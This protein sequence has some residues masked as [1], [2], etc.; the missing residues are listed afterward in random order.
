[1]E[2]HHMETKRKGGRPRKH[3]RLQGTVAVRMSLAEQADLK[4]RSDTRNM[5]V[6]EYVRFVLF[7]QF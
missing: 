2:I 5:T 7:K 3:P 6:S 4:H 1:M